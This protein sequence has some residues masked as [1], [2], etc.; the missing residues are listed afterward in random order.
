MIAEA[1]KA[2]EAL[3]IAA[4]KSPLAHASLIETRKLISEAIQS[5]ES[6]EKEVAF[7]DGNL[8]PPST[9]LVS[10]TA[11]EIGALDDAGERI[12]GWHAVMPLESGINDL[13]NGQHA[14]Q[15]L[16][17]GKSSALLSSS[18]E[19][20]LL[21]DRDEVYQLISS[22]ISPEKGANITQP[23]T[24][25]QKLDGDE[26][27]ESPG[28]EKKPLPNGLISESKIE[29]APSQPPTTTTKK[30]VRGK[31]VEVGEGS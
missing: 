22:D 14:L 21:G 23:S 1:E 24:S 12:N 28:D 5:I 16:L 25:T 13:E 8:S 3:E 19:Y 4:Q 26:A 9:E 15:G 7:T 11:D 31:L 27:N 10:H 2:A 6:I 20:G 17:N 29:E 18:G 30:W